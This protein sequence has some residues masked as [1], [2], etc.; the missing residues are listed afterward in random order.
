ME[1]D[2]PRDPKYPVVNITSQS[3]TSVSGQGE[4]CKEPSID[5]PSKPHSDVDK[6]SAADYVTVQID[7]ENEADH[8]SQNGTV[9]KSVEKSET[10]VVKSF[11]KLASYSILRHQQ[12]L[13][14]CE[15]KLHGQGSLDETELQAL[16]DTLRSY[17]ML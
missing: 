9:E 6:Q 2:S 11:S 16:R 8:E 10:L 7:Q 4:P 5:A 15:A 13:A 3:G 14:D 17:C 1:S 12:T